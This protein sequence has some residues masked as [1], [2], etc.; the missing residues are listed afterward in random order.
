MFKNILTLQNQGSMIC[1]Y[2][3]KRL[4][5]AAVRF[6]EIEGCGSQMDRD[7]CREELSLFLS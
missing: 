4:Y 2:I 7:M 1:N 5:L 3:C 6:A